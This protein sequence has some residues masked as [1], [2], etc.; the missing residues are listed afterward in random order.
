M[1]CMSTKV[2]RFSWV[3]VMFVFNSCCTYLFV[4]HGKMCMAVHALMCVHCLVLLDVHAM[5]NVV[6]LFFRN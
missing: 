3:L 6:Q 5:R 2:D 4:G 1:E